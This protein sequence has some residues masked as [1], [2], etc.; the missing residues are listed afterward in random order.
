MP[1]SV[2]RWATTSCT[3]TVN[4]NPR[5]RH[6]CTSTSKNRKNRLRYPVP[7]FPSQTGTASIGYEV[8]DENERKPTAKFF[9]TTARGKRTGNSSYHH[10]RNACVGLL[11]E[12]G[13]RSLHP[14]G[15]RRPDQLLH[16]GEPLAGRVEGSDGSGGKSCCDGGPHAGD[17]R[18]RSRDSARR[19]STN[20]S[21]RLRSVPVPRQPLDL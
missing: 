13:K 18:D 5:S 7:F 8:H 4:F 20:A 21:G 15:L 2:R 3:V 1:C 12:S 16:K 9:Q 17:D 14:G 10:R 19:R 11:R 6:P